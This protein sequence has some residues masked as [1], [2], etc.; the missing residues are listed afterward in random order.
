MSIKYHDPQIIP[1]QP[2]K[3][4]SETPAKDAL[5]FLYE[6]GEKDSIDDRDHPFGG[7]EE[8]NRLISL[9][10]CLRAEERLAVVIDGLTADASRLPDFWWND[11]NA[12]ELKRQGNVLR[13][14]QDAYFEIKRAR[15]FER[16]QYAGTH[17]YTVPELA[18]LRLASRAAQRAECRVLDDDRASWRE[19]HDVI[20][21]DE[22]VTG[23][24]LTA[25]DAFLLAEKRHRE[26]GAFSEIKN[27]KLVK[28]KHLYGKRWP[29]IVRPRCTR[30]L[31]QIY[32]CTADKVESPCTD[33][34]HTLRKQI[35]FLDD[36]EKKWMRRRLYAE[37]R[38]WLK[39]V[40]IGVGK[41]DE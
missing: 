41:D 29:D 27:Y 11:S 37:H 8:E 16:M 20:C 31:H 12:N 5:D 4:V 24:Y 6:A 13:G 9:D 19:R 25:M 26:P 38:D 3:T 18:A 34:V 14:A 30:L 33:P 2:G 32:Q 17:K 7:Y 36:F 28:G 15:S 39:E 40:S 10:C 23:E 35:E 1:A 21:A 22:L